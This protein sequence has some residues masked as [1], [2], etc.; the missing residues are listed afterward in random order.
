M[1]FKYILTSTPRRGVLQITLNRPKALNALST[2][3]I[4]EVLQAIGSVNN[5]LDN[6]GAVVLTGSNRAFAAGA[7]IKEMQDLTAEDTIKQNFLGNWDEFSGFSIPIIAAVE[8]FALGG[9]CELA[10]SADIIY[11]SKKA[12]FGQPEVKLG[13][14]PGGGGTQRLIRAIGKSR[15]MEFILSG[16]T[17]NGVQA[18]QWGLVSKTFE[19]GTVLEE[20]LKLAERL[21]QGP[22]LAVRACKKAVL[23]ADETNLRAG[24]N[25]ERNIFHSLFG[26]QEQKEG[27]SAFTEKRPAKWPGSKL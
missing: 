2:H 12:V 1:S 8:G 13:V 7:D 15:A 10:M 16:D 6:Y 5:D 17:F 27:M 23:V 11:A 26:S 9:G 25:F 18:E 22:R 24:L 21:A 4:A 3:L 19:P 20:S 14:I